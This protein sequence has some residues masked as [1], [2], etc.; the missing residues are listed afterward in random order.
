[1]VLLALVQVV[2]TLLHINEPVS[3]VKM[4]TSCGSCLFLL[5]PCLRVEVVA[6]NFRK[7]PALCGAAHGTH[8]TGIE[9]LPACVPGHSLLGERAGLPREARPKG[10]RCAREAAE[11][12]AGRGAA[13]QVWP[14]QG[15]RTLGRLGCQWGVVEY[16]YI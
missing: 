15:K 7:K 2:W 1:M 10:T 16:I 4:R 5:S 11:P 6:S 3:R 9:R 8:A 14:R 13:F 12:R